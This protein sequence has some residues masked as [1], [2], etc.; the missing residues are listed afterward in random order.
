MVFKRKI[1]DEL[2]AWKHQMSGNYA[3]LVEGARRIGK[4]TIVEEFAKNEYED[5]L[6]LDFGKEGEAVRSIFENNLDDMDTFFR[7]LF[8]QKGKDLTGKKAVIIFD[9]V[10]MFP[11]A[12]HAIK[13]LV[14]DGRYDYIETG[15]LIR[16]KK[17]VKDIIIPSE[18]HSVKMFPMDFEEF[19]WAQDNTIT[20]QIIRDGFSSGKALGDD[21]HRKIM[22]QNRTYMVVGGMPQAVNAFVEGKSYQQIDKVK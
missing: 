12:R 18:E 11:R 10:Q 22:Q 5:Y 17:N 20:F 1:Y 16:I 6:I 3:L 2:L 4:S 14:E 8:L 9:E 19:L 21:A 7:N 13:Y 15:S